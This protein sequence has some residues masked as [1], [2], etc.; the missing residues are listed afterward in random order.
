MFVISITFYQFMYNLPMMGF[1]GF[2]ITAISVM[3]FIKIYIKSVY[4]VYREGEL[5][6][7]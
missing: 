7:K 4:I 5:Q 2:V 1:T 6:E 3:T